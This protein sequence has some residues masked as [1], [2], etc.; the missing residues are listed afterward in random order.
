MNKKIIIGAIVAVILI[1]AGWY[2]KDALVRTYTAGVQELKKADVGNILSEFKKEIFAPSP[3]RIGG[4][5]NQASFTKAKIIAQ[6][7]IQRFDNG[8]LPP[9]VE[10]AQLSAAAQTKAKDMFAKQYF[11]HVSPAGV[12]VGELVKSFGYDYIVVGENLILGNFLSEQEIVQKWMESPGHRT[13]IL[14]ERYIEIGVAIVKGA[15]EGETVWIGV[16]EFGLPLSACKQADANLKNQIDA[17]KTALETLDAQLK[18]KKQEIESTNRWSNKYDQ[19]IDEYNEL[20]G[21]YN[22]INEETK[23]LI[24]AYNSQVS[25]FN[26]CVGAKWYES[27][28]CFWHTW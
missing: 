3:L 20:V 13:N 22:T 28:Y 9:L 5:A 12:D 18:A 1:G 19:L 7:N 27:G 2:F 11:E 21:Q 4:R 26:Q 24:T 15:Y 25:V 23:R 6:T 14:N 8:T 16:Q 17:N 10:N